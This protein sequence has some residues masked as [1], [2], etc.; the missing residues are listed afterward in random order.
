MILGICYLN[1]EGCRNANAVVTL[2]RGFVC[3]LRCHDRRYCRFSNTEKGLSAVGITLC[4]TFK[5][6]KFEDWKSGTM[7]RCVIVLY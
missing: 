2:S 6:R 7:G 1:F 3:N 4:V 5:M